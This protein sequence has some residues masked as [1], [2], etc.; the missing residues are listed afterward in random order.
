MS[1]FLP[2]VDVQRTNAAGGSMK[3]KEGEGNE[4]QRR[5]SKNGEK[6][7]EKGGIGTLEG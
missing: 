5:Q 3:A 7:E 4:E 6:I 1:L 2:D